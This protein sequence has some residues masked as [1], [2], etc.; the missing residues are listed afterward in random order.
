[1]QPSGITRTQPCEAPG[2]NLTRILPASQPGPW[3]TDSVGPKLSVWLTL[4]SKPPWEPQPGLGLVQRT[5]LQKPRS[6]LQGSP[7]PG[8]LSVLVMA[9]AFF[10]APHTPDLT[11]Q[12]M[13]DWRCR[14]AHTG[15]AE[16]AAQQRQPVAHTVTPGASQAPQGLGP[17]TTA[18]APLLWTRGLPCQLPTQTGLGASPRG[19][20]APRGHSE[21]GVSLGQDAPRRRTKAQRPSR[22]C[23]AKNATASGTRTDLRPGGRQ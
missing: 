1:M 6:A 9:P 12:D 5:L 17:E 20:A 22:V 18:P 23:Y 2:K 3:S 15:S 4:W 14:C 8:A 19:L 16:L 7:F 11:L 21:K 13:A 10:P